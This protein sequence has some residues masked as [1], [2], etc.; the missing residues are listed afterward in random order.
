MERVASCATTRFGSIGHVLRPAWE[1]SYI[2]AALVHSHGIGQAEA[3]FHSTGPLILR[4]ANGRPAQTLGLAAPFDHLDIARG[5]EFAEFL[6][7]RLIIFAGQL[8]CL[9]GKL[10]QLNEVAVLQCLDLDVCVHDCTIADLASGVAGP[11]SDNCLVAAR[12]WQGHGMQFT[13]ILRPVGWRCRAP[14]D[15]HTRR[16]DGTAGPR[17][18][19]DQ[20]FSTI[21]FTTA[22][23]RLIGH[24]AAAI[25]T[26]NSTSLRDIREQMTLISS[27]LLGALLAGC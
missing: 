11:T 25:A 12:A 24:I 19:D 9:G 8:D 13:D 22:L 5:N 10:S 27:Y 15:R 4:S 21:V 3:G 23:T 20:S 6:H 1:R 7:S 18:T 14:A 17:R 16:R 2:G 26:R